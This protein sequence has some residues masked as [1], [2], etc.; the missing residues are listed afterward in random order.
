MRFKCGKTQEELYA[1]WE[2]HDWFAWRPVSVDLGKCVW[3]ETIQR[4][5][6]IHPWIE[7]EYRFK[8]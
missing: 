6:A 7:W 1:E 4:K 3:F 2:W 8:K 5:K